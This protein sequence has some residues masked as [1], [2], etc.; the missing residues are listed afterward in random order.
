VIRVSDFINEARSHT[1][2]TGFKGINFA[3]VCLKFEVHAVST[4][5]HDR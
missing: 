1:G 2:A 5:V 4:K 3:D